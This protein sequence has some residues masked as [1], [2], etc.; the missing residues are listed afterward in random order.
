MAFDWHK[1]N[2]ICAQNFF[3]IGVEPTWLVPNQISQKEYNEL[4]EQ[5]FRK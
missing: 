2:L 3:N 4:K 1:S 5:Y